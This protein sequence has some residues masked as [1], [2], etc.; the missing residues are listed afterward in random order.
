MD[1]S[2]PSALLAL[3]LAAALGFLANLLLPYGPF[4][5]GFA[6]WMGLL[7]VAAVLVTKRAGGAGEKAVAG[8]S[9]L[10]VTAA[11]GMAFRD[12]D[13]VVLAM[14]FVLFAAASMVLLR[15]G[16]IVLWSTR[17]ADHILGMMMVPARAVAG[18]V[19]LLGDIQPPRDTSTRRFVAIARGVLFSAPLLLL[20]GV[21]FV[22]A[23][24]GFDRYAQRVI[25]FLSEEFL[26]R[27]L[28][29]LAFVWIAAGLLSGVRAKRLPD[30]L[31]AFSL[32]RL[33]MEETAVILGLLAL[34]FLAFVA[35]QLG[36]LFGGREAIQA[37]SG[38]SMAEYARRG[39]F[40]MMLVGIATIVLLLLADGMTTARRLF[41]GLAAV[42]I[43]C[44]LVMLI[45]AAQRLTIY[46]D[47]F[48][49]SSDRITAAAVMAW[50][51]M[52]L[53][54]FVATVLRDRPRPF[55]SGALIA[56]IVTAFALVIINPDA[57]AARS[58]LERA[59]AGVREADGAYLRGLSA[60]AVP[61]ILERIGDLPASQRCE[62]WGSLE[63]RWVER[64][65]TEGRDW[66][67]WN[68]AQSAARRA[69]VM[70]V[71]EPPC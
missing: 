40:E 19:P 34:L 43:G 27:L 16:G 41:R 15:A 67:R 33:G 6:I 58:N 4:G 23:D 10:A 68:A 37:V 3:A 69:L 20:F 17:P 22:S 62:L 57:V 38:L 52:V 47:T 21:L 9:A 28:F 66:R 60:D 61:A 12:S 48:G 46:M 42:L 5:P 30:P 18:I 25:G 54:L 71:A 59:A 50:V 31:R 32:P 8:W 70:R 11:M 39:F 56:G 44:V 49:L 51:A 45:S 35:F 14:W 55:A 64:A 63:A 53:I 65:A 7:G 36:Y 24:A 1:R 29:V 26:A 2:D 13:T